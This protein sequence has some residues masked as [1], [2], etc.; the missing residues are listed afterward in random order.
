MIPV[1]LLPHIGHCD[2]QTVTAFGHVRI[3]NDSAMTPGVI[4]N[5]P[6]RQGFE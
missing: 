6:Y 4:Y 3:I 5:K 2:R 1:H